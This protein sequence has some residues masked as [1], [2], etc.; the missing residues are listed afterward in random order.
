MLS[1]FAGETS[2]SH[3]PLRLIDRPFVARA[4]D[5]THLAEQRLVRA[6]KSHPCRGPLDAAPAAGLTE[7]AVALDQPD[8]LDET[9][10]T[11]ACQ[12]LGNKTADRAV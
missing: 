7:P 9:Q 12:R 1:V 8:A 10:A 3:T 11:I 4:D 2:G 6:G 5:R